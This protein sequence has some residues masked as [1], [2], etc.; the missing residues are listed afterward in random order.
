M[1]AIIFADRLGDEL[2]PFNQWLPPALI[3]YVGKP[4]ILHAIETAQQSGANHIYVVLKNDDKSIKHIIRDGARWSVDVT[5]LCSDSVPSYYAL[6]GGV[7][8]K[9][10]FPCIALRGDVVHKSWLHDKSAITFNMCS[11]SA[12]LVQLDE[13]IN[14]LQWGELKQSFRSTPA[15]DFYPLCSLREL[16]DVFM[17]SLYAMADVSMSE[18]KQHTANLCLGRQ[19]SLSPASLGTGVIFA[20]DN[21]VISHKARVKHNCYIGKR[22]VVDEHVLI[23]NSVLLDD[24]SI[25]QGLT[26]K[27]MLVYR[28]WIY[29]ATTNTHQFIDDPAL[30]YIQK[31]GDGLNELVNSLFTKIAGVSRHISQAKAKLLDGLRGI[32]G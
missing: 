22:C 1:D 3:P 5:Y 30:L 27:N 18:G 14:T 25:G 20:D 6:F 19:V 16:H 7:A 31:E 32:A 11:A 28:N 26:I 8:D 13:T 2:T 29:D 9:I 21:S 23:A 24:V 4:L 17:K 15:S 10:D 12:I